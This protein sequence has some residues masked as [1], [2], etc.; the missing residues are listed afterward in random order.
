MDLP[1][2]YCFLHTEGHYLKFFHNV[3][4]NSFATIYFHNYLRLDEM[5]VSVTQSST[6]KGIKSPDQISEFEVTSEGGF[7]NSTSIKDTLDI[8]TNL[9]KHEVM[10]SVVTIKIDGNEQQGMFIKLQLT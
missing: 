5:P 1:I 6:I 4:M 10:N 2:V 9:I 8:K 7:E 3:M